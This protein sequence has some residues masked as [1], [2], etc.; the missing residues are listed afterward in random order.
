MGNVPQKGP[1]GNN[2]MVNLDRTNFNPGEMITGNFKLLSPLMQPPN[3]NPNMKKNPQQNLPP[4]NLNLTSTY[5]NI[6]IVHEEAAGSRAGHPEVLVSQP[7]NFPQLADALENPNIIFPFEIKLPIQTQNFDSPSFEYPYSDFN[8]YSRYYVKIEI[9]EIKAIGMAYFIM[10]KASKPIPY[11][12]ISFQNQRGINM[13]VR[14]T[15]GANTQQ[16]PYQQYYPFYQQPNY[17]QQNYGMNTSFKPGE[18]L[19]FS[20][21]A[22]LCGGVN[23][24]LKAAEWSLRRRIRVLGPNGSTVKEHIDKIGGG[25]FMQNIPPPPTMPQIPQIPPNQQNQQNQQS[26]AQMAQYYEQMHKNNLNIYNMNLQQIFSRLST[27]FTATIAENPQP[28]KSLALGKLPMLS[29][30]PEEILLIMPNYKGTVFTCDYFIECHLVTD[31]ATA[32]KMCGGEI[33]IDIYQP[34]DYIFTVNTPQFQGTFGKNAPA[35]T[36]PQFLGEDPNANPQQPPLP[37]PPEYNPPPPEYNPPPPRQNFD[38]PIKPYNPPHLNYPPRGV[39]N[40][41]VQPG[42]GQSQYPNSTLN[43]PPA[44]RPPYSNTTQ[45]QNTGQPQYNPGVQSQYTTGAGQPQYSQP[46]TQYPGQQSQYATGQQ[47]QYATGQQQ[48]ATGQQPQYATGQQPQYATGQQSQYATGQQPQYATGQ[49]PQYAT[50]QQQYATGQQQYATGQQPQITTQQQY[51]QPQ[52]TGTQPQYNT[53]QPQYSTTQ[54]TPQASYSQPNAYGTGAAP[55]Q[56]VIYQ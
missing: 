28:P 54:Y 19:S 17:M 49:Q 36:N 27:N 56:K 42:Y 7:K 11:K 35:K 29:I 48:Y 47:P 10:K 33:A 18:S 13:Y 55:V 43:P 5:V 24:K 37:P 12:D 52:Y 15:Q 4:P 20:I 8:C 9:N 40:S 16:N 45:P 34:P 41:H 23:N 6:V 21:Q 25:Q 3:P 31:D 22:N 2:I 46:Q 30:R 50:G 44:I 38:L 51:S 53:T 32:N 39:P 14:L 26:Q 1:Q